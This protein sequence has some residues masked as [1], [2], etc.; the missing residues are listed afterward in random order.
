[1]IM[2]LSFI[3][4]RVHS[5]SFPSFGGDS[6]PLGDKGSLKPRLGFS[7]ALPQQLLHDVFLGKTLIFS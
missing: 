5:S 1:M 6:D 4:L 7:K 3:P 2:S